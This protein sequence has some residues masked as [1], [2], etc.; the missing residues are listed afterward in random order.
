MV[1][2][3]LPLIR[4]VWP[5]AV[6]FV[7]DEFPPIDAIE[8]AETPEDLAEVLELL[9]IT[10][11]LGAGTRVAYEALPTAYR[12]A[13]PG[14]WSVIAP[15]VYPS[16]GRFSSPRRGALYVARTESVAEAEWCYHRE[17]LLRDRSLARASVVARRLAI[18]ID[19]SASDARGTR[20]T[21]PE[22]HDPT[23]GGTDATRAFADGTAAAGIAYE[24]LRLE[25]GEC[26]A[27]LR[28]DAV[29]GPATEYGAV[30]LAW[31]VT[32]GWTRR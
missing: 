7:S 3:P 26:L 17:R 9:E 30:R 19:L 1:P 16:R 12:R 18:D 22:L 24:S 4:I 28:P 15:F 13:G 14:A 2:G 21:H 8:S 25:G 31:S 32:D 23:P 20:A 5:G 10:G 29:P 11:S 27:V 6:R